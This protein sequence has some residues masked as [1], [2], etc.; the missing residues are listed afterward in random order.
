M[1]EIEIKLKKYLIKKYGEIMTTPISGYRRHEMKQKKCEMCKQGIMHD[2]SF[3]YIPFTDLVDYDELWIC[4]A[5]A[6]REHGSR[7]KYKW[8]DLYKDLKKGVS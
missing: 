6:K 4:K 1:T 8:K 5:C 7:N 3:R 2:E